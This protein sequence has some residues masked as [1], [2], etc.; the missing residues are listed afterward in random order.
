MLDIRAFCVL[1]RNG[2][3]LILSILHL[4]ESETSI[5]GDMH[6][7][8]SQTSSQRRLSLSICQ[9]ICNAIELRIV[10]DLKCHLCALYRLS[11][12]IHHCNF[13]SSRFWS[14]MLDDIDLRID[15]S[16]TNDLLRSVIT[17]EYICMH[18][19]SST[20]RCIEPSEIK[21]WLRL[22]RTKEVP[23]AI[24]PSFYPG[25]V[26]VSVSPTRSIH[27]TCRNTDCSK[28]CNQKSRLFAAAAICGLD[29][30]KWRAGTTV[31]RHID[32]VFMAPVIDFKH[33]VTHAH[34]LD[35]RSELIKEHDS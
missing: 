30:G 15:R 23:L 16:L 25:M 27:L 33:G 1:Q 5:L 11:F 18:Q 20:C 19:H 29:C 9:L 12:H 35:S 28:S 7:H 13:R 14:I 34:I 10:I 21:H 31:R 32:C 2:N 26:A 17:S 3:L 24:D 8:I 6:H 4:L 22:A